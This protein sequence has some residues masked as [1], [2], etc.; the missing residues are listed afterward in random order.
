MQKKKKKKKHRSA[1]TFGGAGRTEL[2]IGLLVVGRLAEKTRAPLRC[3]GSEGDALQ[4]CEA[5][6]G[7]QRQTHQIAGST[8]GGLLHRVHV[9]WICATGNSLCINT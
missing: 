5:G 1:G 4:H 2:A 6:G 7:G 8:M 9:T 3:A